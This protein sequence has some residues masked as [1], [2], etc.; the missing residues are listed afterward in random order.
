MSEWPGSQ[1][2]PFTVAPGRLDLWLVDRFQGDGAVVPDRSDLDAGELRRAAAYRR[3]ADALQYTAAH[4]ALRRLLGRYLEVPPGAL[5]FIREPCPGCGGPHGRP[6]LRGGTV[7]RGPVAA[8][9]VPGGAVHFSLSHSGGLV[10]VGVAARPVG[11]DVQALPRAATV[12]VCAAALHPAERAELAALTGVGRRELFARLWVRKEAY[13][14]ALGTGLCR[15]PGVDY[16]GA[17]EEL[18]PAGRAVLDVPC[19]EPHFA[20]AAV[21]GG[22]PAVVCVRRLGGEWLTHRPRE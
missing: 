16:V 15:S 22:V 13:L 2:G 17:R 18:S 12:E 7:R 20:A 10:L 14:K 8:G 3:P 9:A 4:V 5:R 6:A 21:R 19:P 1:E 11:V